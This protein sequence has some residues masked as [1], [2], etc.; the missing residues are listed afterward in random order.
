MSTCPPPECFQLTSDGHEDPASSHAQLTGATYGFFSHP[1]LPPG[2]GRSLALLG[3]V[4][5]ER[6]ILSLWTSESNFEEPDS[7]PRTQK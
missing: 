2:L 1:Q 6:G 7:P 5:S 4:G 3:T